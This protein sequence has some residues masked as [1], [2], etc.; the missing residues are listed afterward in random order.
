MSHNEDNDWIDEFYNW[1]FEEDL[2]DEEFIE[3]LNFKNSKMPRCLYQYTKAKHTDDLLKDDLMFLRTFDKLND[4]FDGDF[5]GAEERI[6]VVRGVELKNGDY[7]FAMEDYKIEVDWDYKKQ[8]RAAC[9][10][11]NNDSAP[12]WAFYGENH[13]GICVGYEFH[14]YP[15]FECFCYPVRY[16]ESTNNNAISNQLIEGTGPSNRTVMEIFTK[17]SES[18][19]YEK[20]WRIV[21]SDRKPFK[22]FEF[23][24][25]KGKKYLKFFKPTSVY[26]GLKMGDDTKEKI[27]NMCNER[28]IEVFEMDKDT[29]GYNLIPKPFD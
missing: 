13:K 21:I 19:S 3:C 1:Y 17:K 27:A 8:Y 11:K 18:W 12:L 15:L 14:K 5:L 4:P 25:K 7:Q 28:N 22:W 9:F 29:S 26:L 10:S 20:E 2:S 16:V 24:Q 6:P 23:I